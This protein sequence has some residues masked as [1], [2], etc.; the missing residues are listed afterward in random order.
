MP[1][2]EERLMPNVMGRM[3]NLAAEE[4]RAMGFTD[5]QVVGLVQLGNISIAQQQPPPGTPVTLDTPIRLYTW[6]FG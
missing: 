5:V 2:I 1:P 3:A 4:L 6:A